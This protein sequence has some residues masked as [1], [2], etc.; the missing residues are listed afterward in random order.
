MSVT[1]TIKL[2]SALISKIEKF[3]PAR[4]FSSGSPLF[5]EGQVPIVA[6]LVLSGSVVISKN[7]KIKTIVKEGNIIGLNELMSH[8]PSKFS[9]QVSPE[10]TLC[11]LDKSTMLEIINLEKSELSIFFAQL[12]ELRLN[13]E[14]A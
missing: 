13:R 14:S 8:S 12:T 7:K 5:Y 6:Y 4:K 1:K 9:A 2:D 10:S 11:F 3:S